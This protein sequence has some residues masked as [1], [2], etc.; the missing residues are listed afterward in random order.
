MGD[1]TEAS[2]T[3][4]GEGAGFWCRRCGKPVLVDDIGD[5]EPELRRAVH[6]ATGDERGGPERHIAAPV[7]CEPPLWAAARVLRDQFRGLFDFD[8]RFGILRAD[9][10]DL[11]CGA[12]APHY[13]TSGPNALEDMRGKLRR[14]LV[15][16]GIAPPPLRVAEDA[17]L[18]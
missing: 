9:W 1:G 11:P 7:D 18:P 6:A 8:A 14:A 4:P 10:A 15:A 2:W 12:L 3:A 5:G 17:T 13:T 16:A